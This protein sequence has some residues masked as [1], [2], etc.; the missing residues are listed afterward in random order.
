MV[1]V[2]LQDALGLGE[3]DRMNRPG[4]VGDNWK[5]RAKATQ[6]ESACERM[7]EVTERANRL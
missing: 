5:W 4:T 1:M 6:V 2:Q 3:A 7:R